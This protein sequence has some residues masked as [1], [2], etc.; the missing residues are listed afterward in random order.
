LSSFDA[1]DLE[2]AIQLNLKKRFDE[3][4]KHLIRESKNQLSD[5]HP[6]MRDYKRGTPATAEIKEQLKQ[7]FDPNITSLTTIFQ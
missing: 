1:M 7:M 2:H 4:I 3:W 6:N 5:P